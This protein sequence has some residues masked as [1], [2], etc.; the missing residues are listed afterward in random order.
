MCVA[1]GFA[2]TAKAGRARD[3]FCLTGDG[4][5]QEG[6]PWE[7]LMYAG[8]KR[9][10]NLC[11]LVDKNE[12]QLDTTKGLTI[13][14]VKID[15]AFESLGWRVLSVDATRYEPVL[16]ALREFKYGDRGGKPT[17]I[18]CNSR[19]GWGG[20]SNFMG[21]HKVDIPDALAD[22]EIAL[23]EQRRELRVADLAAVIDRAGSD[24]DA[25]VKS[26][27]D[28]G[29]A[30]GYVLSVSKAGA[31]QVKAGKRKVLV[32]RAAKRDKKIRWAED[33]LPVFDPAKQYVHA[34]VITAAMKVFAQDRRVVSVDSDL[35][36]VSG[37]E[38]GVAFVDVN[39]AINV[40]IAE[41]NM[42]CVGESFAAQGYNAWVS[43]FSP[44]FDWKVLR[45]IAVSYQERLEAIERKDGWLAEGHGL[46]ITFL[47]T[48]PDF[49]TKTNGATHMG[50]DD[51]TVYDGIAHLK[52]ITVSDAQQLLGVM[53]WI[54]E[55]N[56][57]L[58]YL[59]ILRSGA[60][61]LYKK[62]FVFEYGK[63]YFLKKSAGD[64]AYIVSNG[65]GAFE[66][67]EA[68]KILAEK[69]VAVGVVDMPSADAKLI[70][71]LYD[72]GKKIVVAEQNNGFLWSHFRKVLFQRKKV[73][74]GNVIPINLLD[75]KGEARFIHSATYKE[76]LE[77]HGLSPKQI[78]E[79]VLKGL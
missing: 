37:L 60:P 17:A 31:V 16:A 35:A 45:R 7:G 50:N 27:K 38:P 43:T 10:D 1:E 52:I 28:E 65:R 62:D 2:L 56:K 4:E 42:M 39:R 41:A 68:A 47:A 77:N 53:K 40:G 12:G 79:K 5:L 22:Q 57:G 6:V 61:M 24:K 59:R 34:D 75:E 11:V 32:K 19:K 20:L 72:T 78:A 48:A 15:Q 54:M 76:L 33:K 70:G 9:L 67:L 73:D 74:S 21:N 49:E 64:K 23:Q 66:A 71:E 18:I 3:V 51:V 8:A 58:V 26:L 55:G 46:D 30:L 69:G 63:G 36:T 29:A 14:M 25:L 44:F 13:P